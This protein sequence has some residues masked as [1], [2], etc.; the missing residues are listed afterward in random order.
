MTRLRRYLLTLTVCGVSVLG[1]AT[2][3]LASS[4]NPVTICHGTAS[5]HNPYVVITVD[6]NALAAHFN[7]TDPGTGHGQNNNPDRYCGE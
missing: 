7:G 3:S 2:A 6:D 5:E 4:A 1:I